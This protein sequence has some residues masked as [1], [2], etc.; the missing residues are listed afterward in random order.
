MCA[1]D[2]ISNLCPN[3]LFSLR[4]RSRR[5]KSWRRLLRRASSTRFTPVVPIRFRILLTHARLQILRQTQQEE[6]ENLRRELDNE[7]DSIRS[8]LFAAPPVPGPSTEAKTPAP[9]RAVPQNLPEDQDKEYDQYDREL[10]LDRRAK[11]KDR[12]KTEEEVALEEKEALEKAER[13]RLRRMNGEESENE[14]KGKQKQTRPRGGDDLDEDFVE[15]EGS[16]GGLGV[17]LGEDATMSS[18]D[19]EEEEEGEESGDEGSDEEDDGGGEEDGSEA[20]E[21]ESASE[22][23]AEESEEEGEEALVKSGQKHRTKPSAAPK[24]LPYTFLCPETHEEFLEIVEDI[25]DSD[26]PTVLKR[27]RTLY[28]PSLAEENKFKLQVRIISLRVDQT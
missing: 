20:E 16:W 15:E 23:S 18:E 26:V 4:G 9:V 3:S 21:F 13:R 14:G 11:P 7:L 27:I 10:A 2:T 1:S 12:T 6:D 22:D 25:D 19:E 8:L 17:G 28:H 5:L 24:E